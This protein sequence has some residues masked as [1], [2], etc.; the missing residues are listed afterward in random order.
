[1]RSSA[2]RHLSISMV[3]GMVD[4]EPTW[5]ALGEEKAQVLSAFHAFTGADGIGNFRDRKNK[6]VSA[7]HDVNLM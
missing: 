4:V 3:S 5:R 1:M 6:M 2:K 7:V